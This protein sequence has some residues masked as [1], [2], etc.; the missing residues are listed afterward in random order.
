MNIDY[1][2]RVLRRWTELRC[3]CSRGCLPVRQRSPHQPLLRRYFY[4]AS[5]NLL[6]TLQSYFNKEIIRNQF[7]FIKLIPTNNNNKKI[8]EF[9]YAIHIINKLKNRRNYLKH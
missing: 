7:V 6:C 2:F 1:I 8:N 4:T 9:E 3:R 5:H